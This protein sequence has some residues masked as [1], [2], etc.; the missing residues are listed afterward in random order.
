MPSSSNER[1]WLLDLVLDALPDGVELGVDQLLRHVELV[2]FVERVENLALDRLAA[3]RARARCSSASFTAS[4]SAV[5]VVE[6]ER[7]G[8]LVVELAR[9]RA[10]RRGGW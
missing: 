5:D 1:P 10:R 4:R 3:H 6:A 2:A 8:E 7:L 9:L